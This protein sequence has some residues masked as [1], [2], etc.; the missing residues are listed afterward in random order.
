[1]A[2]ENVSK[3]LLDAELEFFRIPSVVST[4]SAAKFNPITKEQMEDD[5]GYEDEAEEEEEEEESEPQ[6]SED[7]ESEISESYSDEESSYSDES[8][9]MICHLPCRKRKR[10]LNSCWNSR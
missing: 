5:E 6:D 2:P 7:W 1:M 10:G 8:E 4:E 3:N 9:V